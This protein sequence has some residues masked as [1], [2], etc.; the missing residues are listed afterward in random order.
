MLAPAY[1]SPNYKYFDQLLQTVKNKTTVLILVLQIRALTNINSTTDFC[2]LC[3]R[4]S[5]FS[6]EKLSSHSAEKFRRGTLLC[7]R[8]FRVS[9]NFMPKRGISRFSIQPFLSHGAEKVRTG[10]LQC[11]TNFG[12][13][14]ILCF[15]ESRLCVEI[16]FVS[17]CRKIS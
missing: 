7:F 4:V 14:K 15:R 3:R 5:R 12:Y 2:A 8:K 17:Q 11:V 6:V 16:F 13:R 9:K 10:T 1:F